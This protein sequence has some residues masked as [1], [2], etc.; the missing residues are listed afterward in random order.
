M[1]RIVTGLNMATNLLLTCLPSE[2]YTRIEPDLEHLSLEPHHILHRPGEE[3]HDLYFPTSCMISITITSSEG[4]TVE[5]GAI[6]RREVVGVNAFMG[7]RETTQTEFIVQ[8]GGD[9]I[10]IGA[11]RLK[12]EFNRNTEMREVMLKYTQAYIAQITQNVAC[13]RL[14]GLDERC[15]RW[16][17]EVRERIESDNFPLTQEFIAEML[18]VRRAGVTE[19]VGKLR[20]AG[21]IEYGRGHIRIID[22]EGLEA[23]SCECYKLLK[24][25]YDR[26][27]G[28]NHLHKG[29]GGGKITETQSRGS[30]AIPPGFIT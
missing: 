24:D 5:A 6:G 13:N 29:A 19:A 9:A 20:D 21:I 1:A 3:I 18:G 12:D 14:H 30:T 26:L 22:I 4:R 7:G 15:A 17:L 8:V 2:V 27:L 25:E 11:A 28:I 10:R 23:S 16:L